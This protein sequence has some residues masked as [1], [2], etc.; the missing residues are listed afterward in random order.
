VVLGVAFLAGVAGGYV[1]DK[2]IHHI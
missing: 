1:I 2:I